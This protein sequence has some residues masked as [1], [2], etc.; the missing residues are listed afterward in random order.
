M[1]I[2]D[3][4]KSIGLALFGAAIIHALVILGASFPL[5]APESER[6]HL[7]VTLAGW[8]NTSAPERVVHDRT[9]SPV[10]PHAVPHASSREKTAFAP[11]T[12]R[13][14]DKADASITAENTEPASLEPIHAQTTAENTQPT[15]REPIHAQTTAG[16]TQPTPREPAATAHQGV[17]HD[18][19]DLLTL[20]R[21]I[22][23][24]SVS[25]DPDRQV[26]RI[27]YWSDDQAGD[28]HVL[29]FYV[30][31][32]QRKIEATGN[33][34]YPRAARQEG[35]HGSLRMAVRIHRDGTLAETRILES[36]G[37]REL[38]DAAIGIVRLSAPFVPFPPALSKKTDI[39]EIIR[40]WQ[41]RRRGQQQG[42]E[43][44]I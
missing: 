8:R 7:T 5:Q 40:T 19:I 37:H 39:L 18:L 26:P 4:R 22:V 24:S 1:H 27:R 33:L 12:P 41:F 17:R 3:H 32:W 30:K 34:F 44:G 2:H 13:A 36:S 43:H 15:P 28:D 20:S 31:A 14:F 9:A 25:L 16:N 10:T 42:H 6:P 23:R 11:N 35:I 38:D 29:N 21:R